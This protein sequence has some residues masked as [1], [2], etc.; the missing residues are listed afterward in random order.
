MMAA[1]A[2]KSEKTL[3]IHIPNDGN[4][5]RYPDIES[6]RTVLDSVVSMGFNAVVVD[7][8]PPVGYTYYESSLIPNVRNAKTYPNHEVSSFDMAGAFI[9]E[10][11][12]RYLKVSLSSATLSMGAWP[13]EVDGP[14]YTVP[15]LEGLTCIEYLP[16]GL[17]DIKDSR[18]H[19]IFAFLNPVLPQVRRLMVD[20]VKEVCSMYKP[21][22]FLL[23][24]CRYNNYH[25]DFSEASRKAFE[26]YTGHE[27]EDFP[28]SI[29]TYPGENAYQIVPG[30]Y[31]RE[32]MEWR[33]MVIKS[34]VGEL[35]AAVKEVSPKTEVS[36]WTASWWP[37]IQ[38]NGQ[39]WASTTTSWIKE[40]EAELDF[41]TPDYTKTGM[42]DLLDVY[43]MG[44]YLPKAYGKDDPESMEYALERGKQLVNGA[45]TF[46]GS[47]AGEA[48]N[49]RDAFELMYRCTDGIAFFCIDVCYKDPS[50]YAEIKDAIKYAK[51]KYNESK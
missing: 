18:E 26:E 42:A 14:A 38:G 33:A 7:I 39:N 2:P 29:Y 46:Y 5:C 36:L 1:C 23:D 32:W 9:E 49:L 34:L 4:L 22:G 3:E 16:D 21:D 47:F 17:H 35:A 20:H 44:A 25:S 50:K 15:Q 24:Y 45:C 19:G 51:E 30:K 31:Y 13:L 40:H 48:E 6:V 27:V 11:H 43:E 12:K 41:A 10:G 28:Y 8:K 37:W